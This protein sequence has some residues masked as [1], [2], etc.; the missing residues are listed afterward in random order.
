LSLR[1]SVE[2]TGV[3]R[4]S[5]IREAVQA[6]RPHL[7]LVDHKPTGVWGE[8][9]PTLRALRDREDH[10]TVILGMRD[11]VDDPD[12]VREGWRRDETYQTISDHYDEVL[13]YG[14][15][16]VFDMASEY[17]LDAELGDRITYCGYV[18]S[19]DPYKTQDQMREQLQLKKDK[20]VVVTA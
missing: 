4:A 16:D 8:L 1:L 18:C 6:F 15:R 7:F 2:E 11:I 10:P 20:L 13:V 5:V 3:L 9:L 14:C 19:Q 12:V 17:G